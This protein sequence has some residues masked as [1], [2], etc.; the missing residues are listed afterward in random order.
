MGK[1]INSVN[2]LWHLWTAVKGRRDGRERNHQLTLSIALSVNAKVLNLREFLWFWKLPL[3]QHILQRI[4]D[5]L[6]NFEVNWEFKRMFNSVIKWV[7]EHGIYP[8]PVAHLLKF[9]LDVSKVWI[10]KWRLFFL[11]PWSS[12]DFSAFWRKIDYPHFFFF[13]NLISPMCVFGLHDKSYNSLY[14][15]EFN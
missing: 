1:K 13:A 10:S 5:H 11:H 12:S 6:R 15:R 4:S 9:I 7:S 3:K 2:S 14:S 8:A